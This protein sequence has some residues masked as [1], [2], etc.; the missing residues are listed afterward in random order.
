MKRA[1]LLGILLLLFVNSCGPSS[2]DLTATVES[3]VQQTLTALPTRTAT[4][5]STPTPPSTTTPTATPTPLGGGGVIAFASGGIITLYDVASGD[6]TQPDI[7]F[8]EEV[9]SILGV[10]DVA[11]SPDGR[12]MVFTQSLC[13]PRQPG[14][15]YLYC[16]RDIFSSNIDGSNVVK[17]TDTKNVDEDWPVWSP[18]GT[19]IAYLSGNKIYIMNADGSEKKRLTKSGVPELLS[20]WSPDGQQIA[21]QAQLNGNFQIYTINS[22]GTGD[23]LQLTMIKDIGS[24]PSWSPDGQKI[25][26]TVFVRRSD[27]RDIYVMNADGS[28]PINL[29]N[30]GYLDPSFPTWSPDG[31]MIAFVCDGFLCIMNKDGTGLVELNNLF[32]GDTRP[33]WYLP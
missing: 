18:D 28:D 9:S 14:Q 8:S 1:S 24:S 25:A 29:T 20:A 31:R 27:A 32:G 23:I 10:K 12:K 15:V 13:P 22:D 5:T 7:Q 30:G 16:R 17:L 33:S 21:F 2:V 26:F 19:R 4:P 3:G 11:V 6:I